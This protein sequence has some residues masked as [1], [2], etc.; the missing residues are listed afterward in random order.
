MAD[1]DTSQLETTCRAIAGAF[2]TQLTWTW[3]ERFET[4]LA[5]VDVSCKADIIR[6]IQEHMGDIWDGGNFQQAPDLVKLVI[7][8]FGGLRP[9]QELFTT[10]TDRDDILLCAWWPWG[11]GQTISIRF[12]LL[13]QSLSDEQNQAF[14]Q[15]FKSWFGL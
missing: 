6:V 2:E 11:N 12:G 14:N 8:I 5:E 4:V 3:D 10:Q 7:K 13:I 15:E 1:Y 9:G